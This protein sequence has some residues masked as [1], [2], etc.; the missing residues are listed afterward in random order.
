MT[1]VYRAS[2]RSGGASYQ[3]GAK[4]TTV[5][6]SVAYAPGWSVLLCG[7]S[8]EPNP[9]HPV[10]LRVNHV[11]PAL[12]VHDQGPRVAGLPGLPAG[13]APHTLRDAGRRELLHPV[14]AALDHVQV[15]LRAERQV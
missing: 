6:S 7:P 14:V 13:A 10:V 11:D 2:S 4:A 5:C 8:S 1:S 12:L 9:L 15:A 3:P